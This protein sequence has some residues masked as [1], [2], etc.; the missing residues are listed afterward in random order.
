MVCRLCASKHAGPPEEI[1]PL[2]QCSCHYLYKDSMVSKLKLEPG[3]AD[4]K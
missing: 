3:D 2:C 4:A 1:R